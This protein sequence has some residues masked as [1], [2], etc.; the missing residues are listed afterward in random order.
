MGLQ[1]CEGTEVEERFPNLEKPAHWWGDQLREKRSFRGLKKSLATG[2]RQAGQSETYVDGLCHTPACPSLRW[3]ST[4]AHKC[5]VLEH[6]FRRADSGRGL[7]LV[8]SR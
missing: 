1:P 8:L 3:V 4:G 5:C 2:E 6:K 7:L